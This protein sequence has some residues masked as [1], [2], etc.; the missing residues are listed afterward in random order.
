MPTP[1][2]KK[3]LE[4]ESADARAD[5]LAQGMRQRVSARAGREEPD[6]PDDDE[7]ERPARSADTVRT[8]GDTSVVDLDE[9]DDEE[10]EEDRPSRRE[11]RRERGQLR[12]EN[13]ELRERLARLEGQTQQLAARPVVQ[14]PAQMQ[15]EPDPY[16]R[17]LNM[18]FSEADQLEQRGRA[19][20]A[21]KDAAGNVVGM[22][23]DEQAQFRKD[24][25][26][27]EQRRTN[28]MVARAQGASRQQDRD[29]VRAL[30]MAEYGDVF[31]NERALAW[32][33][34]HLRQRWAEGSPNNLAT[35]RAALE[36]ARSKFATA[37]SP[38][39]APTPE[40]KAKYAGVSRGGGGAADDEQEPQSRRVELSEKQKAMARARFPKVPERDAYKRYAR[41]VLFGGKRKSA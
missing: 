19:L 10:D 4:P 35:A 9:D 17:E 1:M 27:L 28:V 21:R 18:I 13:D 3:R 20:A 37:P 16:E 32:G 6:E 7:D 26:N 5:E 23:P 36:A 8:S 12:K 33:D 39:R 14:A 38:R 40:R 11:R 2:R 15:Q 24:W 29:P 34:A 41:E 22:T 30:L 25:M 31:A